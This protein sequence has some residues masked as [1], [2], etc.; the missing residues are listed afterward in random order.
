MKNST[1]VFICYILILCGPLN[2]SVSINLELGKLTT[3]DSSILP[4]GTLW[5]LIS[6]NDSGFLPGALA[7]NGSFSQNA[8]LQAIQADFAGA[9]IAPNQQIGGGTVVKTG[10]TIT[11]NFNGNGAF[12]M[13]DE[14]IDF[15]SLGLSQGEKLAVYWFPGLTTTSNTVPLN[16]NFEI[17]GFHQTAVSIESGGSSGMVVPSEQNTQETMAYFDS[18]TEPNTSFDPALFKA[19]AVPEPS[20]TLF[21][22]S[23]ALLFLRRR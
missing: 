17:G 8:N 3:S 16:S 21:L 2:A 22:L 9:Q 12:I 20:T 23:A 13:S 14:L 19:V 18:A 7:E 1:L 11:A 6:Q 4:A 5:A 15:I 10:S